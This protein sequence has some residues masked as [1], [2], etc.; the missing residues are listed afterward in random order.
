MPRPVTPAETQRPAAA[1]VPLRTAVPTDIV[2][3][4]VPKQTG[5][6]QKGFGGIEPGPKAQDATERTLDF[7]KIDTA[8]REEHV[9]VRLQRDL[10]MEKAKKEEAL[11]SSSA[12]GQN[13]PARQRNGEKMP[14]GTRAPNLGFLI[15][16]PDIDPDDK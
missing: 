1:P 9:P 15:N 3:K 7:P 5:A 8:K 4:T 14:R 12:N 2:Y 13:P 6:S 10:E 16:D 11:R